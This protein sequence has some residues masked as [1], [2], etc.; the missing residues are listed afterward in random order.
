TN[1]A[2]NTATSTDTPTNTPTVTNTFTA[3]ATRTATNTATATSTR[4]AT[5]TSTITATATQTRT[6]T[7]TRTATPTATFE[8]PTLPI[9]APD[10]EFRKVFTRSCLPGGTTDFKN[11]LASHGH[12]PSCGPVSGN[13]AIPSTMTRFL[14]PIT[15][16]P[17]GPTSWNC[18]A[19]TT[20]LLS[21]TF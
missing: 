12:L 10:L 6:A 14:P 9:Q 5:S 1:T 15:A 7:H 3:T 2:T 4:T 13:D 20:L 11:P 18:S 21:C 8:E 19:S 16:P 17:P